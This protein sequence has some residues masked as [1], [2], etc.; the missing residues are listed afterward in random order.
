MIIFSSGVYRW[1]KPHYILQACSRKT[2]MFCDLEEVH[3]EVSSS[4]WALFIWAAAHEQS[5]S[6]P[7]HSLC[8]HIHHDFH[9]QI[10]LLR[11][12]S[13]GLLDHRE[14]F[15]SIHTYEF[16]GFW[17]IDSWK[18]F[19]EVWNAAAMRFYYIVDFPT[20]CLRQFCVKQASV[21]QG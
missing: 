1:P 13:S 4:L 9:T 7:M 14:Q 18:V 17:V 6:N 2:L 19:L 15:L 3:S 20:R 10:F 21:G 16:F 8:L 5:S 11:P 12:A